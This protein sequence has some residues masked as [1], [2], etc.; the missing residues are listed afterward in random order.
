M[1]TI[2]RRRGLPALVVCQARPG[3]GHRVILRSRVYASGPGRRSTQ[4]KLA[5]SPFF[6][7]RRPRR[8]AAISSQVHRHRHI[9]RRHHTPTLP[10]AR[11]QTARQYFVR[12]VLLRTA[13][14]WPHRTPS[15]TKQGTPPR[16]PW[17]SPPS[18]P[19]CSFPS[20][21]PLGWDIPF[22]CVFAPPQPSAP[23]P[24][25]GPDPAP[26]SDETQKSATTT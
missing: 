11:C 22:S 24:R 2:F 16:D 9:E 23:A 17:R 19:A 7:D 18:S 4:I 3:L 12:R 6:P 14:G 15:S 25:T 1:H 10:L 26:R 20:R 8:R 13:H 21:V 5:A